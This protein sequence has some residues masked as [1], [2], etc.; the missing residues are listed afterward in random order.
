MDIFIAVAYLLVG[1][2]VARGLV[3]LDR[4][5]PGSPHEYRAP[6]HEFGYAALLVNLFWPA[7][8]AVG[9]MLLFIGAVDKAPEWLKSSGPRKLGESVLRLYGGE[10][11]GAESGDVRLP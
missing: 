6:D 10:V 2:I 3:A 9:F 8:L 5:F 1:Y 11:R 7:F 4:R